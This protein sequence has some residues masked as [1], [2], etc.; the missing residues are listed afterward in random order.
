MVIEGVIEFKGDNVANEYELE[1]ATRKP[2]P[3]F[4]KNPFLKTRKEKL[5]EKRERKEKQEMK[6]QKRKQKREAEN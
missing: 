4:R 5:R 3:A 1:R 6:V 2:E